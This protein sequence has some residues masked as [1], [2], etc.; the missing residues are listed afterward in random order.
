MNGNQL[1]TF[2]PTLD[3]FAFNDMREH[4]CFYKFAGNKKVAWV[5]KSFYASSFMK[6]PLRLWVKDLNQIIA[7]Y[8]GDIM[9]MP[10]IQQDKIEI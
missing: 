2:H 3:L 5:I 10:P 9:L 1:I 6:E 8:I 7:L 4:I